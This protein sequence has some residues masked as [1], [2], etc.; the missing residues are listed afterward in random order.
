MKYPF[1]GL[2]A[3]NPTLGLYLLDLADWPALLIGLGAVL[4]LGA[5]G[6]YGTARP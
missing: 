6:F 4:T 3:N 1:L 2:W 5:I